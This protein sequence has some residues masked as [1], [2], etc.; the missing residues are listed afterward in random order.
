[1]LPITEVVIRALKLN[2]LFEG[3]PDSALMVARLIF[4]QV[5]LDVVVGQNN[6]S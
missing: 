6:D 4:P 3:P 1:M 2:M 5:V